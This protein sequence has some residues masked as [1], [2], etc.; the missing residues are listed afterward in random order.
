MVYVF[1]Y[2]QQYVKHSVKTQILLL[3]FY[4]NLSAILFMYYFNLH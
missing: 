2:F 3:L 4:T 1:L